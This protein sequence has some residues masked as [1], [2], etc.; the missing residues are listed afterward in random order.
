MWKRKPTC[1]INVNKID[2]DP[3]KNKVYYLMCI[4]R[5]ISHLINSLI[6]KKKLIENNE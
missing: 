3:K 2:S 4:I 6:N 5:L 1:Y